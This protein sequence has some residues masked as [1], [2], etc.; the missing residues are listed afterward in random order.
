MT[1]A[2]L[3]AGT[4][5]GDRGTVTFLPTRV[6]RGCVVGTL[7]HVAA[8]TELPDGCVVRDASPSS[9]PLSP[10]CTRGRRPCIDA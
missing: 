1:A 5:P 8:G 7:A 10:G 3:T 9:H 6:G 4:G 2:V